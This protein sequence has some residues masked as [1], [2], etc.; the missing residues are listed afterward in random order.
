MTVEQLN[1]ALVV[2]YERLN[3]SR[4]G[5]MAAIANAGA[6]TVTDLPTKKYQAVRDEVRA[7]TV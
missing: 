2:E 7:L 5:I 4:D 3:K 1:A 6:T